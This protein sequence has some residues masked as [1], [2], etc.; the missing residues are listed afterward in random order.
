M[1]FDTRSYSNG[2]TYADPDNDGDLDLIVNNINVRHLSTGIML[3]R[4]QIHFY[5]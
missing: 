2:S 5:L 1:G 3:Q 4:S